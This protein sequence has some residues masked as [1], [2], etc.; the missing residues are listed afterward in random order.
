MTATQISLRPSASAGLEL[1]CRPLAAM[2]SRGFDK[3]CLLQMQDAA[4]RYAAQ[5]LQN[6]KTAGICGASL[7]AIVDQQ[8]GGPGQADADVSTGHLAAY[9]AAK[10]FFSQLRQRDAM[11]DVAVLA[12]ATPMTGST[13]RPRLQWLAHTLVGLQQDADRLAA[14]TPM[15]ATEI[16]SQVRRTVAKRTEFDGL[17]QAM[18]TVATRTATPID[19]DQVE[20]EEHPRTSYT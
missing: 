3:A 8:L 17:A 4:F 15:F 18:R 14:T 12:T 20:A 7:L 1:V 2:A 11:F 13:A 9:M 5:S 10:A 19:E 6:N 16:S